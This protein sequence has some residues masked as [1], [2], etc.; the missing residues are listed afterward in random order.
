MEKTNKENLVD[1]QPTKTQPKCKD[2][3]DHFTITT[4]FRA[5]CAH[6]KSCLNKCPF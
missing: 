3:E 4:C 1:I 5:G 2:L 6:P